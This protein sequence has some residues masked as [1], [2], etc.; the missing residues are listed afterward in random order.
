MFALL[1]LWFHSE[2]ETPVHLKQASKFSSF[3]GIYERYK[4]DLEAPLPTP[5]S[6]DC[7]TSLPGGGERQVVSIFVCFPVSWR[8]SL[9]L[10]MKSHRTL[11]TLVSLLRNLKQ[12]SAQKIQNKAESII[13]G[14]QN[15]IY[16]E[17][18]VIEDG[19]GLD[20]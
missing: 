1:T 8:T 17:F 3:G 19:I 2:K 7:D 4:S 15:A 13:C 11:E 9:S 6:V 14:I 10:V 18:S 16:K 5:D 20:R 12:K